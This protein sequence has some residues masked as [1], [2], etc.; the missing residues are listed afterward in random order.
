M[1]QTPTIQTLKTIQAKSRADPKWFFNHYLGID[2][3]YK[4]IEIARSI[5]D[6]RITT[7]RSCHGS[8]KSYIAARIALWF[9]LSHTNSK[10]VTTAP[11]MR[12]VKQVL[13][14]E[15]RTA[16]ATSKY[17]FPGKPLT[18][19]LDV[20]DG[21]FAIGVTGKDADAMNGFHAE[22]LLVIVDEAAGVGE[23]I[24]AAIDSLAS[25]A[26]S[27]I[28]Y[29]GNPTSIGGTF[30]ESHRVRITNKITVS[31]WDTPNFTENDI[32]RCEVHDCKNEHHPAEQLVEAIESKRPLK[33]ANPFLVS[34]IWAYERI[35]KWGIGTPLWD[36]RVEGCF[37]SAGEHTLIPLNLI[38]Y[39]MEP[40]RQEQVPAG[41]PRVGV[42][43]A[44]TGSDQSAIARRD[45]YRV[46]P[47]RA[48]HT[49]DTTV[50]NDELRMIEPLNPDMVMFIDVIGVG[51]P[52]FDNALRQAEE[53]SAVHR[54]VPVNVSE[55]PT[56][57]DPGPGEVQ[58]ANLRSELWWNFARL[59]INKKVALP[60]DDEL[61]LEL[62]SVEYTIRKGKVT[63]EEK[64]DTKKRI[65]RSPDKADAVIMSF[66]P[67]PGKIE[68]NPE[69]DQE[70]DD[71]YTG[72]LLDDQF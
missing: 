11:T 39:A 32:K 27:R 56:V 35:F 67:D 5:R 4:Q 49:P 21:W 17:P 66:F 54:F 13:W 43:V 44:R 59:V 46:Q 48:F 29:I 63:I 68:Y 53:Q 57:K 45:G 60:D 37:P 38:E 7:V 16:H 23:E 19:Q 15:L 18:T 50:L 36:S 2:P 61:K 26:N 14:R 8:G 41:L 52:V 9:L 72:G 62:S 28:C 10:V 40:E 31:A 1:S 47:I 64:K 58:F 65:G 30:Y 42:D 33:V 69:D 70:L 20:A 51:G 22:H 34:P 12:Q 55:S 25:S 71:S 6:N 3:W 24:F